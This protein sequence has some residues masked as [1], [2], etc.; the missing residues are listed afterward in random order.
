MD[1]IV[2]KI[3]NGLHVM[4]SKVEFKKGD[5]VTIEPVGKRKCGYDPTEIRKIFKEVLTELR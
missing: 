2:K 4:V 1:G 5:Y 3:G